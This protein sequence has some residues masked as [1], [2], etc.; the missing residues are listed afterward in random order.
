MLGS[1]L[2]QDGGIPG[3]PK[4]AATEV[5]QPGEQDELLPSHRIRVESCR[6]YG[7]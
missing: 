1:V 6:V 7:S 4:R 5:L 2:Q 3:I